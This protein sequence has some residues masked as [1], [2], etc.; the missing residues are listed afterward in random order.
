ME[1]LTPA[2]PPL[3]VLLVDD[4][5]QVRS[6][7]QMLLEEM[8]HQVISAGSGSK[9]LH[10]FCARKAEIDVVLLD[11]LLPDMDGVETLTKLRHMSPD[12]KVV[13]MSGAEELRLRRAFLEHRINGQLRKPVTSQQV[14]SELR[15]ATVA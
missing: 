8:G 3:R 4:D 7:I 12:V 2:V 14:M 1:K 9:A 6:A 5:V 13:L 11:F 15:R 10:L